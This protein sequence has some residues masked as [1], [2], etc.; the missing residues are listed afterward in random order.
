MTSRMEL[1][2]FFSLATKIWLIT[3]P[4]MVQDALKTFQE[5]P[6]FAL[7]LTVVDPEDGSPWDFCKKEKRDKARKM[8]REQRPILLIGSPMCTAFCTC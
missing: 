6:G 8:Q 1:F 2:N 4:K 3:R 7:D 5:R